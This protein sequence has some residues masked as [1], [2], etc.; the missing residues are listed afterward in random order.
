MGVLSRILSAKVVAT[1]LV[2]HDHETG[3][4]A[5]ASMMVRK[6]VFDAVGLM[7]DEYFLYFEETDFCLAAKRAGWRCWYVPKSRVVHL[8]GQ[9]TGVTERNVAPRRMPTYWF[10]SRRRY[11]TKNHGRFY[12]FCA[13]AAWTIGFATWRLRRRLQRKPD[14]DPPHLLSDFVCFNFLA[15]QT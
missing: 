11:F 1:P 12:T 5:G 9:S 6:A 3:W 2:D 10:A 14:L 13:D 15:G 4:V 8:V 7:D